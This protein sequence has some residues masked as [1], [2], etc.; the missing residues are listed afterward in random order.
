[1][2]APTIFGNQLGEGDRYFALECGRLRSLLRG[3]I[4]AHEPL[5][6]KAVFTSARAVASPEE[7][8]A[9]LQVACAQN[10]EAL[11]RMLALLRVYDQEKSFLE[12]PPSMFEGVLVQPATEAAGT[13]IGPYKLLE[14][15]GEGG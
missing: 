10:P 12:S 9:Y 13:V 3:P 5:D 15:I 6:E 2:T 8:M 4:M 7:R 1:M 11:Q 14:Q